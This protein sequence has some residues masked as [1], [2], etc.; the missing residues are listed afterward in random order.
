M[1]TRGR[2]VGEGDIS[3][4]AGLC[5]DLN[6]LHVDEEFSATTE[7]GGRIAHDTGDAGLKDAKFTTNVGTTRTFDP[8]SPYKEQRDQAFSTRTRTISFSRS[9][10]G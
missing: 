10:S 1:T 8:T 5:G 4:F 7:F 9:M 6:P 3:L 2:T